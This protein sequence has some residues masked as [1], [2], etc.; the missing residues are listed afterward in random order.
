[1]QITQPLHHLLKQSESDLLRKG[2]KA[3]GLIRPLQMLL[4]GLGYGSTINWN[5]YRADGDY[6][7]S[8]TAALTA[9]KADNELGN[10]GSQLDAECLS[11]LLARYELLPL[12][13]TLSEG[14]KNDSWLGLFA[15]ASGTGKTVQLSQALGRSFASS[16]PTKVEVT[17]ALT[18]LS[19]KYGPDWKT[20]AYEGEPGGEPQLSSDAR[21]YTIADNWLRT[22]FTKNKKGVWTI[23]SDTPLVFIQANRD[24]LA[25]K[26]LS[27]SSIRIITPVS[28]NE[29]NLNAINT[30]DDS[31]MTFGMFQWTLGQRNNKGELAALLR[32]LKEEEPTAY[33]EYFGQYGIDIAKSSKTTGFISLNGSTIDTV[34]EKEK[35]RKGPVWAFR[36]WRAGT[37]A[38]V[39]IVQL[40]HAVDRVN[41]FWTNDSYRPLNKFYISDLVTSEYGVCL[42]LDHHVNRPG[43]L[44]SYAIGKKDIVGQAMR[45]A[46]L[47]NT[48]PSDWGTA[49]ESR[50]LAA[51][52]P[53]RFRSSMTHSK[54]RAAKIKT[55][56]DK[57][58][59]S[60]ERHSYLPAITPVATRSIDSVPVEEYGVIS[61]EHYENRNGVT[62]EA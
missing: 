53:L 47:E 51:Y 29:G 50:L 5:K 16:I 46:K 41:S 44:M 14:L 7:G 8:T 37:D 23:G 48:K 57:G 58:L 6:G 27:D 59:L 20:A 13:R 36:F 55:Y 15:G 32:R 34:A 18:E 30:W 39:N 56:L 12:L 11:L 38:R 3:P 42:L 62:P 9:F 61:H 2:H 43:H 35:F 54:E 21:R 22:R 24:M 60:A 19:E 1:M 28:A 10:D 49:E 33:T 31:F 52:L 26:G 17:E 45:A 40:L 25:S 4:Y